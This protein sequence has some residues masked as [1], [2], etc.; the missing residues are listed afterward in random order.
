MFY[1]EIL[2]EPKEATYAEARLTEFCLKKNEFLPVVTLKMTESNEKFDENSAGKEFYH[3][4]TLKSSIVAD[5][6]L[7]VTL[8]DSRPKMDSRT[9]EIPL[10]ELSDYDTGSQEKWKSV[11]FEGKEEGT[12]EV[13]SLGDHLCY[14]LV[15]N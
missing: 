6:L 15:F 4:V 9:M 14:Y 11:V 5:D 13:W 2:E 10:S 3:A 8:S 7:T 1:K 12:R